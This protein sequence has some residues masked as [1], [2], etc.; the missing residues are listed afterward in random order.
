[1]FATGALDVLLMKTAKQAAAPTEQEHTE[2]RW[3]RI[4]VFTSTYIAIVIPN[5]TKQ[6]YLLNM[7]PLHCQH[8]VR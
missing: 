5:W 1:M 8:L 7:C 4:Q 6:A 3:M 2:A